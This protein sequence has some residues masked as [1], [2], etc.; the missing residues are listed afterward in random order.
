MAIEKE[1]LLFWNPDLNELEA[2][3]TPYLF[4][5]LGDTIQARFK[6]RIEEYVLSTGTG[7]TGID[8]GFSVLVIRP[9]SNLTGLIAQDNQLFTSD[10]AGLEN[11]KEGDTITINNIGANPFIITRTIIEIP[12]DQ[13]LLVD[14]PFDTAPWDT[15]FFLNIGS[16]VSV[17]TPINAMEIQDNLIENNSGVFYEDLTTGVT[18]RATVKGL[19]NTNL[20]NTEM[21]QLGDK[22]YQT[23][24][25]FVAGNNQGD[26]ATDPIVSQGFEFKR[27]LFI[28]PVYRVSESSNDINGIAP[29]ELRNANSLK[30]VIK[31]EASKTLSDPNDVSIINEFETLGNVGYE[32]ET[33]N[34]GRTNYSI[35][36][37]VY[38]NELGEVIKAIELTTNLQTITFDINN[39]EDSPWTEG[40]GNTRTIFHITYKPNSEKDYREV[41]FPTEPSTSKNNLYKENFLKDRAVSTLGSGTANGVNFGTTIQIVQDFESIYVSN[42]KAQGVVQI[43]MSSEAVSKISALSPQ[44]Y[45]CW[46]VTANHALTRAE[47]DKVNLPIDKNKY[48]VKSTDPTMVTMVNEFYDHPMIEG[49]TG[50]ESLLIFPKDHY[51]CRT[52]IDLDRNNDGDNI[53]EGVDIAFQSVT[54]KMVA[55]NSVTGESFVLDSFTTSLSDSVII[56]DPVYTTIPEPDVTQD[57]GFATPT[58]DLRRN[59]VVKRRPDLETP[60][61][62]IF[63]YELSYPVIQRSDPFEPLVTANNIFY[64]STAPSNYHKGKNHDWQHYFDVANWNLSYVAELTVTK[65]GVAELYTSETGLSTIDYTDGIEWGTEVKATFR[66]D[67]SGDAIPNL[68]VMSSENTRI[69]SEATYIG[70]DANPLT[71]N[72][73]AV[74]SLNE[75][76]AGNYK[77]MNYLSSKHNGTDEN[78]LTGITGGSIVT[79]TNPSGDIFRFQ[80]EVDYTKFTEGN[81]DFTCRIYDDRAESGIPDGLETETGVLI[82]SEIGVQLDVE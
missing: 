65:D 47:S 78:Q 7:T 1:S 29:P 21:K 51:V 71:S 15:E 64:D 9:D 70:L 67:V 57:R 43:K 69:Q 10:P 79:I 53:R 12:N 23:G 18:R 74:L 26:G 17:S 72:L 63:K 24:Q 8:N 30:Y 2:D 54:M 38:K 81:P 56:P 4:D 48:F 16:V 49:D 82:T 14:L 44:N 3:A 66:T 36:N 42:S 37:V 45:K 40:T 5:L 11:F 39:T 58:D 28:N 62:G 19:D 80:A 41:Q 75:H 34:T 59:I 13:M 68:D 32:N 31:V 50:K 35:S 60:A 73:V 52:I 77:A 27:D 22:S 20:A 46:V 33:P 6:F 55:S 61:T 25:L 76:D